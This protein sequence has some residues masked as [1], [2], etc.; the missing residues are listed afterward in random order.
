MGDISKQDVIDIYIEEKL[1]G[2]ELF[3]PQFIMDKVNAFVDLVIEVRHDVKPMRKCDENRFRNSFPVNCA[4]YYT[5][6]Y[7]KTSKKMPQ[8]WL[9]SNE[10]R[11]RDAVG[12]ASI[13]ESIKYLLT[14]IHQK[15]K[16]KNSNSLSAKLLR[17]NK[18]KS[19][20]SQEDQDLLLLSQ[21]LWSMLTRDR[22]KML[23]REVIYDMIVSGLSSNRKTYMNFFEVN[24]LGFCIEVEKNYNK[25]GGNDWNSNL[26]RIPL[27]V[28]NMEHECL[29]KE[30]EIPNTA[31]ERISKI[32]SGDA[33]IYGIGDDVCFWDYSTASKMN[34][35][36]NYVEIVDSQLPDL[37]NEYDKAVLHIKEKNIAEKKKQNEVENLLTPEEKI[38]LYK[39][40]FPQTVESITN[41]NQYKRTDT[42]DRHYNP[43]NRIKSVLRKQVNELADTFLHFL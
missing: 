32:Y 30:G 14:D 11:L 17:N 34:Y 28:L 15:S 13:I 18:F 5:S 12:D 16:P 9:S 40:M 23:G 22:K 41:I 24:G 36:I 31:K 20:S 3:L 4:F 27:D 8:R 10:N 35:G 38:A 33:V 42:L 43:F 26:Y 19:Q 21:H 25:G 2:K 1:S 37:E 6:F 7:Y 29:F 39:K